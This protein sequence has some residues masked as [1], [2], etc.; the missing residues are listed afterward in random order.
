MTEESILREVTI[1]NL[2]ETFVTIEVVN[3]DNI[4]YQNIN[5]QKIRKS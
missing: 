5:T 2:N 3:N 1:E 4:F